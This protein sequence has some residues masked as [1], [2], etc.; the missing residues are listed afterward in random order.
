MT[1]RERA[2]GRVLTISY[3]DGTPVGFMV[4][5]WHPAMAMQGPF[6]SFNAAVEAALSNTEG[7]ARG[8][9]MRQARRTT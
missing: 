5:G 4:K 1:R 8:Q 3:P 7:L 6:V 2:E 9:Q